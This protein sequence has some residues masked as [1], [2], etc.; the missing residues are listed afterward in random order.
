MLIHLE[1]LRGFYDPDRGHG[2]G[3][4]FSEPRQKQPVNKYIHQRQR[5]THARELDK[6]QW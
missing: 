4:G 1:W 6:G 5:N 3:A 2:N